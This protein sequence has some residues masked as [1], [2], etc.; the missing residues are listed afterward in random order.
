M[1]TAAYKQFVA[2]YRLAEKK[3]IHADGYF[4]GAA[5]M[6]NRQQTAQM[7]QAMSETGGDET[8][9]QLV[10]VIERDGTVTRRL[11]EFSRETGRLTDGARKALTGQSHLRLLPDIALD[12]TQ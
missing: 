7:L 11:M 1:Y 8:F 3:P 10:G 4:P 6:G 12:M 9:R 5:E 2:A